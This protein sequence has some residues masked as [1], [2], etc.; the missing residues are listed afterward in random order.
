MVGIEQ[1]L[2]QSALGSAEQQ[3]NNEVLSLFDGQIYQDLMINSEKEK[4]DFSPPRKV[5]NGVSEYFSKLPKVINFGACKLISTIIHGICSDLHKFHKNDTFVKTSK[6]IDLCLSLNYRV[7]SINDD[8]IYSFLSELNEIKYDTLA[9]KVESNLKELLESK[10]ITLEASNSDSKED[11]D[12]KYENLLLQTYDYLIT[13][14]LNTDNVKPLE[15]KEKISYVLIMLGTHRL[16]EI[17]TEPERLEDRRESESAIN[18]S[19]Q[20]LLEPDLSDRNENVSYP[21]EA[22]FS[23]TE[24]DKQNMASFLKYQCKD[25]TNTLDDFFLASQAY[26]DLEK[27]ENN[28]LDNAQD[29]QLIFDI[30]E[31][32]SSLQKEGWTQNFMLNLETCYEASGVTDSN[33]IKNFDKNLLQIYESLEQAKLFDNFPKENLNKVDK[34]FCV[35]YILMR[36]DHVE[37][38]KNIRNAPENEEITSSLS[39]FEEY[40]EQMNKKIHSCLKDYAKSNKD[41]SKKG[42]FDLS[43]ALT[44]IKDKKVSFLEQ[45]KKD[46][47]QANMRKKAISGKVA[48]E[49]VGGAVFTV[50]MIPALL[51]MVVGIIVMNL[52]IIPAT[53]SYRHNEKINKPKDAFV[54]VGLN[55]TIIT[56]MT[57]P[58]STNAAVLAHRPKA[59]KDKILK[60]NF[61]SKGSGV[62]F[63][64]GTLINQSINDE[65]KQ[66]R[67]R[68]MEEN[69]KKIRDSIAANNNFSPESNPELEKQD[70]LKALDGLKDPDILDFF[71]QFDPSKPA[72]I[73]CPGNVNDIDLSLT[74]IHNFSV[75]VGE[76]RNSKDSELSTP[77]LYNILTL[78][79]DILSKVNIKS[80]AVLDASCSKAVTVRGDARRFAM[81]VL[82]LKIAHPEMKVDLLGHSR[83]TAVIAEMNGLYPGLMSLVN[84]VN[85][86][87]PLSQFN[88][89]FKNNV[90]YK[91]LHAAKIVNE[92]DMEY[93]ASAINGKAPKYSDNTVGKLRKGPDLS[94]SFHI[95]DPTSKVESFMED[96]SIKRYLSPNC[97]NLKIIINHDVDSEPQKEVAQ[98]LK[99]QIEKHVKERN[100]EKAG[101][102]KEIFENTFDE[103][104]EKHVEERN[105][106]KA[107]H[108]SEVGRANKVEVLIQSL[109]DN[110][111]SRKEVV[112]IFNDAIA[113]LE[114]SSEE[115]LDD[116]GSKSTVKF[117]T[118]PELLENLEKLTDKGFSRL[119]NKLLQLSIEKVSIDCDIVRS[120][121]FK[122]EVKKQ[123]VKRACNEALFLDGGNRR[124][125]IEKLYERLSEITTKKEAL[126][127]FT[128]VLK[129]SEFSS[130]ELL[131]DLGNKST[132]KFDTYSELLENLDNLTE[133]G[134]SKL[135]TT[136]REHSLEVANRAPGIKADSANRANTSGSI[137]AA[138]C[139]QHSH[140]GQ[141]MSPHTLPLITALKDCCLKQGQI[142][143][144]IPDSYLEKHSKT[145]KDVGRESKDAVDPLSSTIMTN[146]ESLSVVSEPGI[147]N[148]R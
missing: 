22:V 138:F 115:L 73:F 33:K 107:S 38:S 72:L 55:S 95:N 64:A 62:K 19:S 27:S 108:Y 18:S 86:A 26:K 49:G 57:N 94:I 145:V 30:S 25:L 16:E 139:H 37:L 59:I 129:E 3:D 23:G 10:R 125:K 110:V 90:I 35:L 143:D 39:K 121:D 4:V 63:V 9:E 2:D 82:M 15:K 88:T 133:K 100:D 78:D 97:K 132:V 118:Y 69:I 130:E 40:S 8:K 60:C 70:L 47:G 135:S 87:S 36:Y 126:E 146:V 53:A 81:C 93:I 112:E 51:G 31:L 148:G 99:A 80:T 12:V 147:N 89:C 106:E 43:T 50:A 127:I 32:N 58:R 92:K 137:D 75:N 11:K 65:L 134:F 42:H 77:D 109:L 71:A 20:M 83:G 6:V 101:K 52:T 28:K 14:C 21:N 74:Q 105:D 124:E 91:K 85:I 29:S 84:S 111:L 131:D 61:N 102:I 56:P 120:S 13:N 45:N 116:R 68:A 7:E 103:V 5:V 114:F 66:D 140:G 128:N 54:N 76:K 98:K 24:E 44:L 104:I 79:N 142:Q 122:T 17:I 48:A 123:E 67:K 34:K 1:G 136:L 117:D 96:E 46:W 41:S 141:D 144:K 119:K 113:E